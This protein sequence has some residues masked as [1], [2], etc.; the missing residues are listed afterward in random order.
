[1]VPS[2]YRCIHKLLFGLRSKWEQMEKDVF[3]V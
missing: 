1:M 2:I 3:Q